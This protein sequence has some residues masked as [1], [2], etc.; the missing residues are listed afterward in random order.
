M[1]F[2]LWHRAKFHT[3]RSITGDFS[4]KGTINVEIDNSLKEAIHLFDFGKICM[5]C[6]VVFRIF[7][8]AR[9]LLVESEKL[10]MQK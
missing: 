1:N 7:P 5:V 9:K 8:I 10:W 6:V 3:G 2:Q 4:L